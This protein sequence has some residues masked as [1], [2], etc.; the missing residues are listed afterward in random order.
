MTTDEA[1]N[2]MERLDDPKVQHSMGTNFRS[3]RG[4]IGAAL[5]L[6]ERVRELEATVGKLSRVAMAARNLVR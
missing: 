3:D 1:M 4:A 6:R 2:W 5:A